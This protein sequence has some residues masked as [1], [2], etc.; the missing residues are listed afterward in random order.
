M[1]DC[2]ICHLIEHDK[3]IHT[4][5]IHVV[6]LVPR[7]KTAYYLHYAHES[8]DEMHKF[9]SS[10]TQYQNQDLCYEHGMLMHR[11]G[12]WILPAS[13]AISAPKKSDGMVATS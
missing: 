1:S 8:Y 13:G 9:E 3:K 6:P 12:F 10:V 4:T 5:M 11:D 7:R 2:P